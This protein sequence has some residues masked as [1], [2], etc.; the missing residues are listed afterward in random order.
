[1]SFGNILGCV[2]G[3]LLGIWLF[4]YFT[5]N[6]INKIGRIGDFITIILLMIFFYSPL[7]DQYKEI[8]NIRD[9]NVRKKKLYKFYFMV[10]YIILVS[11]LLLWYI[12]IYKK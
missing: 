8:K 6:V 12:L 2:S 5:L 10:G 1:M 9:I 3:I 11:L 7:I 4:D